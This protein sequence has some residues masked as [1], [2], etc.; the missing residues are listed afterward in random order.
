MADEGWDGKGI[1][2]A[3]LKLGQPPRERSDLVAP[4]ALAFAETVGICI[5]TTPELYEA[6][7]KHQAGALKADAFW[8][9]LA[10]A[11]GVTALP[12]PPG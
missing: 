5:V 2:V 10:A 8:D 12:V 9:A 7:R 11:R 6:L 3:N 4:N 1:I